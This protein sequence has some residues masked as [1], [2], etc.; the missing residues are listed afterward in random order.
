[1]SREV[2]GATGD[3]G[4]SLLELAIVILVIGILLALSVPAFLGV[5]SKAQHRLS[6]VNTMVAETEANIIYADADTYDI[7]PERMV[8]AEPALH[9]V[10]AVTLSSG[11]VS[12]GP[13]DIVYFGDTERFGAVALSRGGRCYLVTDV[14]GERRGTYYRSVDATHACGL[15]ASLSVPG[16]EWVPVT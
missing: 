6:H 13:S 9:F 15:P 8:A 10:K 11:D 5:R 3:D 4:F 7:P 2:N 14:T 16:P 12:A 1:M